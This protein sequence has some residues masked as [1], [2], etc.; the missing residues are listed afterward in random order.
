MCLEPLLMT[1]T[2]T[3]AKALGEAA[4]DVDAEEDKVVGEDGD[5]SKATITTRTIWVQ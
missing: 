4:E 5:G 2:L 3:Q 1:T